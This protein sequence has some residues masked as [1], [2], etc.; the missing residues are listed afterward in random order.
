MML[1][2]LW[3]ISIRP[4]NERHWASDQRIMPYADINGS[5]VTVHNVRN[6][7]YRTTTDYDISY[8]NHIYDLDT[9][10]SVWYI[11]EPFSG[12]VGAAH[13]FLSFGFN[14]TFVAISVEIRKEKGEV[15]SPLK[16]L[17]KRYELM[18]VVADE[19]DVIGLRAN[20]RKDLVY[21]YPVKT[22]RERMKQLLLDMLTRANAVSEHPEFYNTL[23]NTC[24]TNIVRHVNTLVP[25]RVPFSYK[26]LMPKYSDE[27]AYHLG[28][29]DTNLTFAEAREHFLIN[30]RA[31]AFAD[32]PAFSTRIRG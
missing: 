16:G 27:L 26:V 30:A 23:T 32:D 1:F 6:F 5:L 4:S 3:Y 28:L 31:A 12:Y 17:F 9:L 2:G 21:V 13:T 14:D 10:D 22:T 29:I 19:H 7:T 20:Y 25:G 11:V 8:Y 24:T 18:Y 15:F